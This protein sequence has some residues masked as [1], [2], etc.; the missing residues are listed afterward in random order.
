MRIGLKAV[1]P[2]TVS[3]FDFSGAAVQRDRTAS[4]RHNEKEVGLQFFT[5]AD[6]RFQTF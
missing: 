2:D 5:T 1:N 4:F 6:M 3:G